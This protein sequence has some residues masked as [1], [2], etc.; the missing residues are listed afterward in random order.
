MKELG[1]DLSF[2]FKDHLLIA[3]PPY[4]SV[5]VKFYVIDQNGILKR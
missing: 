1:A 3:N 5:F 4:F 2:S